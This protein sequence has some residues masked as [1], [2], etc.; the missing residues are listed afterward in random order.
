MSDSLR[1]LLNTPR[2]PDVVETVTYTDKST[3]EKLEFTLKA[4][5]DASQIMDTMFIDDAKKTG[6]AMTWSKL[7]ERDGVTAFTSDIV[8]LVKLVTALL[9]PPEGAEPY[10]EIEVAL[11]SKTHGDLFLILMEA[12]TRISNMAT[13]GQSFLEAQA[14]N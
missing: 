4:S 1:K 8:P 7:L 10:R 5:N 12:A 11:L 6:F 13:I 2:Q 3:G 14:G 9:V